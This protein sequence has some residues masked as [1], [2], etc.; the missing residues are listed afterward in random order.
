[1][2]QT[3]ETAE[4]K[5]FA[6]NTAVRQKVTVNTIAEFFSRSKLK[7]DSFDIATK[8]LSQVLKHFELNELETMKILKAKNSNKKLNVVDFINFISFACTKAIEHDLI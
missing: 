4:V 6:F 2:N 3:K 5:K 8:N 7:D 1:M